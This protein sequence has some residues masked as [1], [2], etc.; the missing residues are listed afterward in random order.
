M[1]SAFDLNTFD[2]KDAFALPGGGA[3]CRQRAV[4]LC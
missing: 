2:L 4:L 1:E 3:V